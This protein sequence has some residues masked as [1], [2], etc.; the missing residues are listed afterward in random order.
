MRDILFKGPIPCYSSD[1]TPHPL[2]WC[3]VCAAQFKTAVLKVTEAEV[4]AA[5]RE[6]G[7]PFCIDMLAVASDH[8]IPL[9]ETA[10]VTG[11]CPLFV[12]PLP[13]VVPVCWSHSTRLAES[14]GLAAAS[15]GMLPNGQ[16]VPLLG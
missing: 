5:Q 12:S 10:V 7:P 16:P 2:G 14:S 11:P 4:Q 1:G 8:R 15:A 6:D 9:P 13:V 3:A